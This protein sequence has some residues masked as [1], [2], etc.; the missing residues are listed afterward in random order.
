MYGARP[1]RRWVQKNMMTKLSEMLIKGE[2]DEGSTISIDA[3][4][5]KKGLKYEVAKRIKTKKIVPQQD[6]GGVLEVP[7]SSTNDVMGDEGHVMDTSNSSG[8]QVAEVVPVRGGSWTES[9]C[10]CN[11]CDGHWYHCQSSCRRAICPDRLYF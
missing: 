5:D 6:E 8:N 9:C 1:I 7:S 11:W 2:I 3:T 4:G 10:N